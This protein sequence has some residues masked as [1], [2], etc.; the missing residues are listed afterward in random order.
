MA[1]MNR[2]W[3]LF[4]PIVLLGLSAPALASPDAH[5]SREVVRFTGFD[6]GTI[7]ISTRERRLYLVVQDGVALRYRV[8]VGQQGMQWRGQTYIDGRHRRPAWSPP[9]IVKRDI[10]SLPD[11]IAGGTPHNPMGEAALTLAGGE[12]AIHGTNRPL[13]VGKAVSYGCFRMYNADVMD[14]FERVR[15]GTQVVV[16]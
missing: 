16:M 12:Y 3:L 2:R 8:A 5:S 13:S 15:V 4:C 14:L 11:V 10:P 7:V 6:V 9:S 1:L